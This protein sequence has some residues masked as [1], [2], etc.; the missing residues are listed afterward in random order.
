MLDSVDRND[1][2]FAPILEILDRQ[3]SEIKSKRQKLRRTIV[4]GMGMEQIIA[5][6]QDLIDTTLEHFKSE[7]R[8]MELC[9]FEGLA[10]HRVFHADLTE[11]V[12]RIW[13]ELELRRISD[14]MELMNFFDVSLAYH[15]DC[16]D[17]AFGRVLRD[18]KQQN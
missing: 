7:E 11:N 12:K 17:G 13:S 15:L 10:A 16:E 5:C 6:A 2:Q 9:K 3:H 8:A 14:A 4:E 1:L 18:G